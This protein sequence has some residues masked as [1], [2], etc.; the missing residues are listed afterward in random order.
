MS[1]HTPG[2]WRCGMCEHT[3]PKTGD[4]CPSCNSDE[5][6]P[7]L[8][9]AAPCLLAALKHA[10][11]MMEGMDDPHFVDVLKQARAAIAKAEGGS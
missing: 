4:L 2:P 9:A 7:C 11:R 6:E 1:K 3:F 8:I 10:T 5:I